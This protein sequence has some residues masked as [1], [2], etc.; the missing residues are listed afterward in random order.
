MHKAH[1]G[2]LMR[3]I[4][5]KRLKENEEFMWRL[6][7]RQI[8]EFVSRGQCEFVEDFAGPFTLLVIADL[9]GVPEEDQ[10]CSA[11]QLQAARRDGSAA[12]RATGWLIARSS[13]STRRFRT[14]VEDR[15][16]SPRDD[17]ITG[18]ATATFPDGSLPDVMDVVRVAANLFAAGQE[19]TVR[20]LA[21]ALQCIAEDNDL[22]ELLRNEREP[23]PNFVEETLRFESPVKGDFRLSRCRRRLAA[24]TS[25]RARR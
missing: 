3:L 11:R 5:P 20:L 16:R 14:Y 15:R 17:V 7:D 12:P 18:L 1:R 6:A 10:R 22:Q 25:V 21:S 24:S 13:T 4:T 19:T 9:L 2:L 23:I 8:D